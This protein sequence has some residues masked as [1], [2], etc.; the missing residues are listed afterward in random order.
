M[1]KWLA[2]CLLTAVSVGCNSVTTPSRPSDGCATGDPGNFSV[3]LHVK[4]ASCP[5]SPIQHSPGGVKVD[6]R[7]WETTN[8][9]GKPHAYIVVYW[10]GPP[11]NSTL[12]VVKNPEGY[13]WQ[14]ADMAIFHGAGSSKWET[15]QPDLLASAG[16]RYVIVRKSGGVVTGSW[17]VE[18]P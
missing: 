2:I 16:A 3:A 5:D 9:S 17:P 1:S 7:Y 6:A 11:E 18:M 15:D 14:I 4:R 12:H 10:E 8:A 13:D